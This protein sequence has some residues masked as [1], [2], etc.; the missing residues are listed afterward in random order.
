MAGQGLVRRQDLVVGHGADPSA[1]RIAG[2]YRLRPGRGIPDA[3]GG[4][5]RLRMV[6]PTP[7]HEWRG[8]GRLEAPHAGH[9]GDQAGVGIV[10]KARPVGT[11]IARIADRDGKDIGG[12]PKVIAD[13]EGS[14]LLTVEAERIDRI[15]ERD[16]VV[17]L[18]GKGPDDT[19]RLVEITVDRDDLCPG[20]QG[21]EE[22]ADRD[23][24]LGQ[25]TITSIPAAAP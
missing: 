14:G 7:D 5:D 19:Q 22:L 15:D 16:R 8:A 17:V 21:L 25:D 6:H 13:F 10:A 20:D 9:G 2:L 18:L 4:G 11:D 3:D 12:S 24:A 1:G 23:L